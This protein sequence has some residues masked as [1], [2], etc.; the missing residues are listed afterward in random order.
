MDSRE[1]REIVFMR[2]VRYQSSYE[3][4]KK[5]TIQTVESLAAKDGVTVPLE[6]INAFLTTELYEEILSKTAEQYATILTVED[7]EQILV[8]NETPLGKKLKEVGPALATM[9]LQ[10]TF[11]IIDRHAKEFNE[12]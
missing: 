4:F 2:L 1:Q 8:F 6:K 9:F 7:A 12:L 11:A 10:Q 5:Q 3:D